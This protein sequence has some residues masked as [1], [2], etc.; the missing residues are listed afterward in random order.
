M[1]RDFCA[2]GLLPVD[3]DRAEHP[4]DFA[5]EIWRGL[6]GTNAAPATFASSETIVA[7]VILV[8]NGLSVLIVDNRRAFFA[9]IALSLGGAAL[10]IVSL[11][12]VCQA[13]IGGFTF[14]V[15]IGLGLYLPYIAM[16]TTILE[17]LIAMTR[18]RCN[19]GFLMYVAD[20]AGYL[21]YAA[22]MIGENFLPSKLDPLHFFTAV[23]WCVALVSCGCLLASWR[24]FARKTQSSGAR[25]TAS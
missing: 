11:I 21:G 25:A 15:L 7:L 4:R 6:L 24:Y 14:M 12:G 19:L 17:R 10:M 20:S 9:S 1:R 18:D 3:H 23:C 16:H 8:V 5:P 13:W 22:L 2:R